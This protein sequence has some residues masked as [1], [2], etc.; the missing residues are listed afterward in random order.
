MCRNLPRP[1]GW[2]R[3]VKSTV[4]QILALSHYGFTALLVRAVN[5]LDWER[6]PGKAGG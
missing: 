3:H 1:R 6:S 2:D 5:V 4:L